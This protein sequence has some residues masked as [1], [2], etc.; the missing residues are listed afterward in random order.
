MNGVM[1]VERAERAAVGA[2]VAT[3]FIGAGLA[4]APG[5]VG[6]V[7]GLVEPTGARV[8]GVADL[9]LVPG[10][11]A[12]RPRWPWMAARG[13]LNVAIAAYGRRLGRQGA[14]RAGAAA[15]A[16]MAITVVDA[17]AAATLA[18]DQG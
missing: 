8:V 4:L 13:A 15:R 9:A 14:P 5:R 2:G 3:L 18:G 7:L 6:P 11:I 1:S 17:A 16:L 10:L 12:G